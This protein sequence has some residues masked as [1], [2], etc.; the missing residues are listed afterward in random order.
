L[1][2]E[3]IKNKKLLVKWLEQHGLKGLDV[4]KSLRD[5]SR[6]SINVDGERIYCPKL[7]T[8]AESINDRLDV[9]IDPTKSKPLS[10]NT[11]KL[12]YYKDD[13]PVEATSTEVASVENT[14]EDDLPESQDTTYKVTNQEESFECD[15]EWINTL[16][17]DAQGK[18]DLAHYADKHFDLKL[19]R[20]ASLDNMKKR[21]KYVSEAKQAK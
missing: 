18:K 11:T 1:E 10:I 19:K 16:E 20:T 2:I 9:N 3:I 5:R 4:N 6:W 14:I 21:L 7:K 13:V 8:L 17:D 12:V 15:W